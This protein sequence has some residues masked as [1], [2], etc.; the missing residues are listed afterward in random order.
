MENIN[1]EGTKNSPKVDFNFQLNV[2]NLDGSSYMEKPDVFFNPIIEKF[3]THLI[4][5]T[6]D[7]VFNFRMI[8]FNSMSTR[9]IMRFF[10]NLEPYAENGNKVSIFWY[11]EEDD[12][13]MEELGEEFGEDLEHAS[14]ALKEMSL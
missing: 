9:F 14:F 1:I 7:V 12:D 11:Y 10:D 5:S 13:T 8:Y 3:K 4:D 2:F 6:G